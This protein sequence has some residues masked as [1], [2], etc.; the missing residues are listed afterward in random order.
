MA[1]KKADLAGPGIGD[2][3]ELKNI[4]PQDYAS[5]LTP[6]ETMKAVFAVKGYIEDNL[7]RELNLMM[8]QVPLIVDVDSGV[9]DM[10]DRD[11][12]RTPIDFPCGLGLEKPIQAQVVQAAT[13]WKRM[14]LRQFDCAVGEGIC[15]EYEGRAQRLFSGPRS[16]RLCR[17]VGLGESGIGRAEESRFPDG[18][19]QK[20]L[21]G[22]Q[23]G[24]I[25]C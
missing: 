20:D 17:P 22:P 8:V 13:K 18:R 12:S 15:T 1:D 10:L 14:A 6:K 5:L 7:C 11:G 3:N 21:E 4:L 2:Y 19:D 16:Q 9:N 25:V 24:R 23:R